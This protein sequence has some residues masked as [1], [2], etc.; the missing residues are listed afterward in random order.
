MFPVTFHFTGR[1]QVAIGGWRTCFDPIAISEYSNVLNHNHSYIDNYCWPKLLF[2]LLKPFPKIPC[3]T[4]VP[5]MTSTPTVTTGCT[6]QVCPGPMGK[7]PSAKREKKEEWLETVGQVCKLENTG[8]IWKYNAIYGNITYACQFGGNDW[9]MRYFLAAEFVNF[10]E[11]LRPRK[12]TRK[13]WMT[14]GDS[15]SRAKHQGTM[16]KI[17]YTAWHLPVD[18]SGLITCYQKWCWSMRYTHYIH[19]QLRSWRFSDLHLK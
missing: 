13:Q 14:S 17:F 5:R 9:Q 15:T 4:A 3:L 16:G 1:C 12:E 11:V 19:T 10:P 2:Q 18:H 8:K 6:R 7:S